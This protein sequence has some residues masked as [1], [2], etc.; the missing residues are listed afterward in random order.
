MM[1]FLAEKDPLRL[2]GTVV[3]E[4]R[5]NGH[6]GRHNLNTFSAN[7]EVRR[8][9]FGAGLYARFATSAQHAFPIQIHALRECVV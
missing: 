5:Q 8:K 3:V 9:C 6:L 4:C 2:G 7:H 1:A